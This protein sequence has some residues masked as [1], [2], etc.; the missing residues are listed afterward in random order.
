VVHRR[1]EPFAPVATENSRFIATQVPAATLVELPGSD[2]PAYADGAES[3]ASE[4][5]EFFTGTRRA[6][7]A[8]RV[9]ATLLF[10]DIVGSTERA[11]RVGDA[12]WKQELAEHDERARAEIERYRGMWINTTGDGLLAMFDGPAR[13]VRC[14]RGICDAVRGLGIEIRAGCHTGEVELVGSDVRGI[15]VHIAARVAALAGAGE[16]LVS[17]TVKDLV[18]GS[19]LEFEDRGAHVLKGVP[20]EWRLFAVV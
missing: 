10:T 20:E 4:I 16:V 1:D 14:A 13:G 6:A 2:Q 8:D 15:A 19:G 7:D 9:L 17:R 11:A 3:L 12:A 18:A 5:E